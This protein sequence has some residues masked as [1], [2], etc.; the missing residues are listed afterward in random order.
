MSKQKSIVKKKDFKERNSRDSPMESLRKLSEALLN[1]NPLKYSEIEM[2]AKF[3]TRGI[4]QLTKIDYDNVVKK[5]LSLG[6]RSENPNGDY[7][8]R[9]QPE[10]LDVETGKFK[11]GRDSE[12]FRVEIK[13]QRHIQ[14]YCN[15]NS[16][17]SILE[18]NPNSILI[19]K[20]VNY[21][22]NEDGEEVDI[23]SADF[24]DFN[25]RVTIKKEDTINKNSKMATELFDSWNR[26][27]KA[28]RYMNRVSFQHP[29][30]PFIV[31]LS[32]VKSSN[33]TDQGWLIPAYTI[34]ESNVFNNPEVY[35]MEVE[36]IRPLAK[37]KYRS[38]QQLTEEL[39]KA[40]KHVLCGLQK[41]NFPIS[42][43]EQNEIEQQYQRLL[44]EE[45][46]RKKGQDF[47]PKR[48][49]YPN[50]FL[51]PSLVT[52]DTVNLAPVQDGVTVPT[53]AEPNTYCVT[54][55]ADG[56]RN[57]L[58]IN[59]RGRV[60]LINMNMDVIFT[61]VIT[62]DDRFFNSLLDGELIVHNKTGQFIN[63]FAAFDIYYI[64]NID[65][66]ARPFINTHTKDEKV[67]KDGCRLPILKELV[68]N[69]KPMN[70]MTTK[71]H[72]QPCP[73]EIVSKKFYPSFDKE[74]SDTS[75]F[76]ACTKI[77]Q[78]ILDGHYNYEVDGLIFTPTLLGV[79]GNKILEAGPKKKITWQHIFKWKPSISTTIFPKSY[80]SI[81]FL[82]VTKKG[83][84]GRDIV[85]PI[86]QNGINA[87]EATQFNQ[88]KTLI[89]TVGYDSNKHGY[90]NPCQ[91]LLNDKFANQQ[92][93]ENEEGYKP[94]Q[95]Y[96]TTPYD[97][98][99]G[100]CNI[101]LKIDSS[102]EYKMFT[103]DDNQ[104]FEDQTVVEF[105]YDMNQEDKAW[106]WIPMRVRYDKTADFKAGYG[107]GANDYSTAN[108]N[109][110]SIHNPIT[111]E[112]L[113][114]GRNIPTIEVSDDVYYNS[115][116]N[117][118][119]TQSMRDFHNL[120]VK[121]A[122][123]QGASKKGNIL[124]DFACGKGGD[125][126]K[127]ISAELSFCFGIDI[128][129]D[130]IEN[131]LNGACAR[132]LNFR[133]TTKKMPYALFVHGNSGLN[134]RSGINMFDSKSN[135][136]TK[137]IFG[138]ADASDIG[139]AVERQK[140]RAIN[141]FDVGSC[142]FAIHYMFENKKMFYNFIRNVAE[143]VKLN[144][145]FIGTCYDGQTVFNMLRK[146]AEGESI[147]RYVQG[148]KIWSI[149]KQYDSTTFEPDETSLGYK[150][151]VYQDTINQTF[152][153]YLVNFKFL[154]DTMSKYGF[155]LVTR[156]EAKSLKLPDGSGMFSEL[157]DSMEQEIKRNPEKESE[158]KSALN[159]TEYEKNI[160]FL[161]RYFVF[162]KI[163]TRNAEQ[164]TKAILSGNEDVELNES[165]HAQ[166][167]IQQEEEREQN[168]K[169][170][171]LDEEIVIE[172]EP[173]PNPDIMKVVVKKRGRKPKEPQEPLPAV[174]LPIPDVV[175]VVRKRVKKDQAVI[176]EIEEEQPKVV[177]K[178]T[179]KVAVVNDGVEKKATRKKKGEL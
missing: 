9:I 141:G 68:N 128:S 52:L 107:V 48:K 37:L 117:D 92:D 89:L 85:T 40:I 33:K 12:R 82:V 133:K 169:P 154:T 57:L 104:V 143:C 30:F 112:M 177:V 18:K 20:K 162:K 136:I 159:M 135:E 138:L 34:Q 42:Y 73:M 144:G 158:Y 78:K 90:I 99:A 63:K 50:D 69:L 91:D 174:D 139:P 130:N 111:E 87:Y 165:K 64:N 150:I 109:W 1:A 168:D 147:E 53:I 116:G 25:F 152:S 121:R 110:K 46:F 35:E 160:S 167:V 21:T 151:D 79:G 140:S 175:K 83:A 149:I 129:K 125:L 171:K 58:Y 22:I 38:P 49:L 60:Y 166:E 75:I 163:S 6:W 8:L 96:P 164:L 2:E 7:L 76:V 84:D 26:S 118:R 74:S 105:R 14:E 153:E 59:N 36:V 19:N 15:T 142:Q 170:R 51:G 131:R 94:K 16:L 71:E 44:F 148:K 13:N 10:F 11:I 156:T 23:P 106:R 61:G 43:T 3:G 24:N 119:L 66:R 29:D 176:K 113:S 108:N 4:K 126:P 102:G 81:D 100:I 72:Y 122:L 178:K 56:I 47:V 124:I 67:F 132:Y 123:I 115:S 95:F 145:Y 155:E 93:I 88:Y 120:F 172:G 54:E 173:E 41:T 80:N 70:I 157:F 77:L 65:I 45:D 114:T 146:K 5:L 101:M 98:F 55:K 32:I 161:N 17:A 28:F 97:P 127:W 39:Q 103:E 137:T 27:K 62:K 31:D 179:R 86:F 134:I